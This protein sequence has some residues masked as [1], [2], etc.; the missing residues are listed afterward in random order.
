V[1]DETALAAATVWP[2]PS[3]EVTL[4]R[5]LAL[6]LLEAGEELHCMWS[7]RRLGVE[8]LDIDHCLPWSAWP[9]GDLWNLV[10]AH[11]AVNQRLKR[12]RLP[13]EELLSRAGEAIQMWWGR[14]YLGRRARCY[15]C[16]S[17]TRHV[18]ACRGW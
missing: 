18:P 9:C 5:R 7:G 8:T 10:P 16:A 15:R 14:A 11:R 6:R 17:A 13:A 12:D 4:P 1:V 3:R 2:E